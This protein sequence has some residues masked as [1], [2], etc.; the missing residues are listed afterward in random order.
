MSKKVI[1][2][3]E[4]VFGAKI[5]AKSDFRGDDEAIVAP[6]DWLEV[7]RFL[8]DDPECEMSH[9]LDMTACDYP[10]REDAAR[11]DV[12]LFV[13][14]ATKN[15]RVRLKTRVADGQKLASLFPVWP[16]ASWSEREIYDMF[17]IVFDGHPDLRRIL[18]YPEFE[19]HPLRKDYPIEKTQPLVPYR[20]VDGIDKL[21]PFGPDMGQPW[22]RVS[23][24][25]RLEGRDLQ[26]S[27]AIGTQQG[28]RPN[29]SKGPEYMLPDDASA[30]AE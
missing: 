15:H 22:T 7:A 12:L 18:M 19:G 5:L 14:S 4:R 16:G 1:E 29:V 2:R 27:P 23:W 24:T 3:L 8:R 20:E 21:P 11:F 17:G 13:R 10:L 6:S 28:Q 30:D 26:V 9:Y 25:E